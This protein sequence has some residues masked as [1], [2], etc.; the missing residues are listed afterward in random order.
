[1]TRSFVLLAQRCAP[2]VLVALCIAA[3]AALAPAHAAVLHLPLTVGMIAWNW[4]NAPGG[5]VLTRSQLE[6]MATPGSGADNEVI[7]H[8]LF[9]TQSIANAAAGPFVF[10]NSV[11][12]DPTLSNS[13]AQG[14]LPDPYFFIVQYV[15]ADLLIIPATGTKSA[16][17]PWSDAAEIL[18]NQRAT[19]EAKISDKLYGPYPLVACHGLGGVNAFGVIEGATADPGAGVFNV[20]NGAPGSGGFYVGGAWTIG[21][22]SAF[23]VTIRLAGAPTLGVTTRVRM[24]L[25]GTLYRALR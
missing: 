12:T 16:F 15:A 22:K 13:Q 20:N 3:G 7:P 11:Q 9:D 4:Q 25:V 2:Y 10:F 21:P 5:P 18:V 23:N 14:Q 19:F 8:I 17:T 6:K 1:M 24:S